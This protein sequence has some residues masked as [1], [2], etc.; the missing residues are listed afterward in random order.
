MAEKNV[1]SMEWRRKHS[2]SMH[3]MIS[4]LLKLKKLKELDI[5]KVGFTEEGLA[6]FAAEYFPLS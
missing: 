6:K 1:R 4:K 2:I 5:T 3:R